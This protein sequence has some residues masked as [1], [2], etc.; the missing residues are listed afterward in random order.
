MNVDSYIL[1]FRTTRLQNYEN[2]IA[3]KNDSHIVVESRFLRIQNI[4]SP[5]PTRNVNLVWFHVFV[6]ISNPEIPFHRNGHKTCAG[7][8]IRIYINTLLQ[9]MCDH[10]CSSCSPIINFLRSMNLLPCIGFVKK[11]ARH[12]HVARPHRIFQLSAVHFDMCRV[13]TIFGQ[14]LF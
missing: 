8:Y 10:P 7:R 9:N 11:S 13:S 5:R 3:A 4:T 12:I 14:K 1:S 6:Y 2:T